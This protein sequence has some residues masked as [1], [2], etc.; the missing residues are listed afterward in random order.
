[1]TTAAPDE[2]VTALLQRMQS[3]AG[4][5]VLVV[6]GDQVVG[7]VAPADVTKVIEARRLAAQ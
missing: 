2:P 7:I 3:A 5:R 6:E 1:V 4:G